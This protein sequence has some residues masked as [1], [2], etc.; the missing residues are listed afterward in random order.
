M[1]TP[2]EYKVLKLLFLSLKTRK[3]LE[4]IRESVHLRTLYAVRSTDEMCNFQQKKSR[5]LLSFTH[6]TK[7]INN[8][9][10]AN[11]VRTGYVYQITKMF[12]C[13]GIWVLGNPAYAMNTHMNMLKQ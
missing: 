1:S 2:S 6:K 9:L 12:S 7:T 8:N 13:C 5:F 10:T 3:L 11:P 4:S